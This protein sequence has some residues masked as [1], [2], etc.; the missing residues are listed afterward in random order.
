MKLKDC[1]EGMY[2]LAK[3]KTAGATPIE[4]FLEYSPLSL[5]KINNVSYE[6]GEVSVVIIINSIVKKYFWFSPKDLIKVENE[7][8]RNSRSTSRS[9]DKKR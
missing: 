2:V 5:G 4:T 7:K 8:R 9:R 1:K 3:D 6:R